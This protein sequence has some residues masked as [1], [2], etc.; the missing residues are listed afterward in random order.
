MIIIDNDF[1]T[2][3]KEI[4]DL[5]ASILSVGSCMVAG[6]SVVRA[7]IG[8][9]KADIDIFVF[10]KASEAEAAFRNILGTLLMMG[11]AVVGREEPEGSEKAYIHRRKVFEIH[12]RT[13]DVIWNEKWTTPDD[14]LEGFD[15]TCCQ[16][17]LM[18]TPE[19]AP[20][21]SLVATSSG[22]LSLM[23]RQ[24]EVT[25]NAWPTTPARA[26]K[27]KTLGFEMLG[28]IPP[29]TS[30]EFKFAKATDILSPAPATMEKF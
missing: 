13:I 28:E 12:G 16:V 10:G 11:A 17:G 19:S 14:V 15:L 2:E 3:P 9:E 21:F 1:R 26:V 8:A 7:L 25:S 24:F 4:H 23:R 18:L 20:D 27:Y 5:L 30:D 29:S 22:A 6:G